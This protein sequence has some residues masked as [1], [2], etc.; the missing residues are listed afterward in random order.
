MKKRETRHVSYH[1][2]RRNSENASCFQILT[3]ACQ[4]SG[5]NVLKILEEILKNEVELDMTM[6]C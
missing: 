4:W 1:Y 6:T 2:S 3:I 5:D